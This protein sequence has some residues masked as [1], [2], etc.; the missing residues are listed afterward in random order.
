MNRDTQRWRDPALLGPLLD[1]LARRSAGRSRTFM[2]V[3]GTHESALSRFGLRAALPEGLRLLA[4]PGCPVCVC[5]ESVVSSAARLSRVR[6]VTVATFGDMVR[7]PGRPSLEESRAA[8]GSVRVVMGAGDAWEYARAHP[9]EEVVFL[10][11]G[12]ETTA[13]TVAAA[14]LADP[15]ANLSVL[16][17]H[18][19]IPPALAAL[20]ALPGRR[21]DGFLL[22]G[23]VLAVSGL[24]EYERF[25]RVTGLPCAVAGFEPADILLGLSALVSLAERGEGRVVN[26]YPRA[27]TVPGNPRAREAMSRAFRV[28][29][30]EWRGMGVIAASGLVLAAELREHDA[31]TRFAEELAETITLEQEPEACGAGA[32]GCRCGEV[33]VGALEP[34]EC[35]RFGRDCT[36]EHPAGPCMVS[37]EG[38]CRSRL[39]YGRA[40][41]DTR[42]GGSGG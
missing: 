30:A 21:L 16:A 3:C 1:Q 27:V 17:A 38:T 40:G 15:P 33:M 32:E 11:V 12:F 29:D 14:L 20:P 42:D 22:P 8:G 23:H 31:A 41:L 13:C 26:A 2:H 10:A 25:S 37:L 18:R 34:E 5:P 28:V 9:R 36:P 35:A 4:G 6:G 19:L 7:V 39:L 24:E